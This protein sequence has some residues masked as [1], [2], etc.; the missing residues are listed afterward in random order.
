M[1]ISLRKKN[2][3]EIE[4]T[5]IYGMIALLA[6]VSAR[7]LPIQEILPACLFRA[8][9]GIPCPSCGTTRVLVHL[10]HGDI[11]GSLLL[12]PLFFLA[13]ITALSLFFV[14]SALLPFNSSRITLIHT[15][16][17]GTFLRAGMAGLFLLNWIYLIF[18]R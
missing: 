12:N 6:L 11:A 10:A 1:H 3:G 4:F 7:V 8:A 17:E 13:M 18:T 14:R 16:R 9:T 15:R 2:A 5:I